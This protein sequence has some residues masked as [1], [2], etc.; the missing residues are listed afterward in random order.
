[1]ADVMTITDVAARKLKELLAAEQK[2]PEL[3][4]RVGVQGGGCSGLQYFLELDGAR[5]DDAVV[6]KDGVKL[7]VDPKSATY[8]RGSQVDFVESLHDSGFR[9]TNPNAKGTCGCGHSFQT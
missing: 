9:L 3:G 5:P 2:G 7:L 6:E 8:V 4:L 1:M